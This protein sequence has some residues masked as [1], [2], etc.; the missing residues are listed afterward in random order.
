MLLWQRPCLSDSSS[1]VCNFFS[2]LVCPG[3]IFI[4]WVLNSLSHALVWVCVHPFRPL[5]SGHSFSLVLG[6]F[7][8]FSLFF[9]WNS[10]YLLWGCW[11]YD[12]LIFSRYFPAAY[13]WAPLWEIPWLCF[14]LLVSLYSW[15]HTF[16][17]FGE[18][19]GVQMGQRERIL[20]PSAELDAGLD[21]RTLIPWPEQNRESDA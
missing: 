6:N 12:F 13:T 10:H 3:N 15:D 14:L 17:F 11:S 7:L 1:F 20:R 16:F 5:Q 2:F 9:P 4:L 18:R 8:P 21:L 19:E